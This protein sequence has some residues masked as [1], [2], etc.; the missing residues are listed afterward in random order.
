MFAS[1]HPNKY[2]GDLFPTVN[3]AIEQDWQ[4]KSTFLSVS[5]FAPI[6][7]S[8]RQFPTFQV[9]GTRHI[10]PH[11]HHGENEIYPTQINIAAKT[12]YIP[13]R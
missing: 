12:K 1:C 8:S 4:G 7:N 3:R 6:S 13:P 11:K 2:L 9:D 5:D 10:Y